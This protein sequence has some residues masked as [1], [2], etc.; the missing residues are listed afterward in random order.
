MLLSFE[1]FRNLSTTKC[2]AS[3]LSCRFRS[4]KHSAVCLTRKRFS[5]RA[6]PTLGRTFFF[7]L[8]KCLSTTSEYLS[9]H[10]STRA[11]APSVVHDHP[12]LR[13][14]RETGRGKHSGERTFRSYNVVATAQLNSVSEIFFAGSFQ[15][16]L[17]H[18]AP[19]DSSDEVRR[20]YLCTTSIP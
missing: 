19:N 13:S 7:I 12:C 2:I 14:I 3:T 1:N 17:R 6:P 11:T 10:I 15:Y 4:E 9:F 8:K 16:L 18:G 5:H 20:I